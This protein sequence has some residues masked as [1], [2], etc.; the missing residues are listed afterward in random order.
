MVLI[1]RN[2]GTRNVSN[3]LCSRLLL[4]NEAPRASVCL[5]FNLIEESTIIYGYFERR[6][7]CS[8]GRKLGVHC[9]TLVK[10]LDN[11]PSASLLGLVEVV[12]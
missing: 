9:G 4:G 11:L 2:C 7:T 12:A 1:V 5:L 8:S 6:V 10:F 3:G